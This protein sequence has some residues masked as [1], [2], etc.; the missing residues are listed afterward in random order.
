MGEIADF[1]EIRLTDALGEPII[2]LSAERTDQGDPI[3]VIADQ[4]GMPRMR[5]V[6]QEETRKG[7][8]IPTFI[9]LYSG[10]GRGCWDAR[11]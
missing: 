4:N 8:Q 3:F 2:S 1:R 10:N 7:S 9:I 6:M 5:L 11:G